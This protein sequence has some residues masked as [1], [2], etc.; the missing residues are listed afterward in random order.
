MVT[1]TVHKDF[2]AAPGGRFQKDG[3]NSGETFRTRLA[4]AFATDEDVIIELDGTRGYGA[5]FLEEAF[6]GLIRK[7]LVTH[8]EIKSRLKLK[9]ARSYLIDEIWEYINEAQPEQS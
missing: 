6:G 1:I 2:S 5:S 7:G 4:R 3:P 8:Q 9:S